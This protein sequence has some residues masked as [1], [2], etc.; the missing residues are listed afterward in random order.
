MQLQ[1]DYSAAYRSLKLT[2]DA[3]GVLVVEFHNKGAPF[4]FTAQGYTELVD[5]FYGIAQDRENKIVI[6][7]GVGGEFIR[8]DG[9]EG[10]L[11]DLAR[12]ESY[13]STGPASVASRKLVL[14]SNWRV[15][16]LVVRALEYPRV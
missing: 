13:F 8:P 11:K 14:P 6:P 3:G 15:R 10:P 9:P 1:D 4:R 7:T 12:S 5:A 16:L 2:R